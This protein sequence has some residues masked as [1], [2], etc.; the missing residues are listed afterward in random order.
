MRGFIALDAAADVRHDERLRAGVHSGWSSGSGSGSVTSSAA[1]RRPRRDVVDERVG[2]D[3]GA[4]ADVDDEGAV[5]QSGQAASSMMWRVASPPGS[6]TMT[7]SAS[8]KQ[9]GQLV[10]AVHRHPVFDAGAGG[11]HR[12]LDLERGEACGD[13]LADAAVSEQ[14]HP[15]VGQARRTPG[16]QRRSSCART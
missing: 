11:H 2:V 8:G 9:L 7:I 14:Q 1:R 16:A 10:D 4:A 13:G 3:E 5:G 15:A 6:V 12:Q